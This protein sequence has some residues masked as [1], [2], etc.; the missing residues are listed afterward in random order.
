MK[1]HT[2]S[3]LTNDHPGVLQRIAGLFA[4][5]GYNI[6]SIT[7]G[8]SERETF[9][10]MTIV[11][12]GDDRIRDQIVLQ[13]AKLIDVIDVT[14]LDAKPMVSRELMLVKLQ[15]GPG[16]RADIMAIAESFRCAVVDVSPGTLIVQVVGDFA[17]NN[18]LLQLLRPFRVVE[19]TRTGETAMSRSS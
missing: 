16:E 8:S 2:L 6:E 14:L 18:A 19:L 1:R 5:R 17:K 3:V 7:V 4:R 13:L 11:A 12:A 15:A 9:S 10:R